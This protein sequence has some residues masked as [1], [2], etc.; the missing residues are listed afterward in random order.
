MRISKVGSFQALGIALLVVSL[1]L[2]G[3]NSVPAECTA[4][5]AKATAALE[6]KDKSAF[7]ALVLPAQRSGA[8]GLPT[9]V[10]IQAS[11]SVAALTLDDVLDI[12]FFQGAQ[13]VTV[14]GDLKDMDDKTT[15]RLGVTFDYGG[16][17]TAIRTLTLKK[18]GNDWLVD[19]KSTLE[20]WATL[21]GAD[22]FSAIGVK[23]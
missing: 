22:A 13:K 16:G 18:E 12:E 14:N 11:K 2:L 10:G 9:S 23:K 20:W 3:C 8:L 5:H 1:T 17:T 4:Q 21:N 6:A 15:A 7:R 19:F